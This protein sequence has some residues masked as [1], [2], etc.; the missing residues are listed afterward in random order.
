MRIT[1]LTK[2]DVEQLNERNVEKN[3]REEVTAL[4]GVYMMC[5]FGFLLLLIMLGSCAKKGARHE[6]PIGAQFTA[7]VVALPAPNKYEVHLAWLKLGGIPQG[8]FI[9]RVGTD[10]EDVL[11]EQLEAEK[12]S[13]SDSNVIAGKQYRYEFGFVA[14]TGN[15]KVAQKTV[16]I[17][18]DFEISGTV[19]NPRLTNFNRIFLVEG[20]RIITMGENLVINVSEVISQNGIIESFPENQTAVPQGDG[21]AGGTIEIHARSGQGTLFIYGSGENGGD[22]LPGIKGAIGKKGIQGKFAIST[23]QQVDVVCDCGRH[24]QKLERLIDEGSVTATLEYALEKTRHRCILQPGDG[25]I[26]EPGGTGANGGD[27][28]RGGDSAAVTVEITEPNTLE[29][30]AFATPGRGGHGGPGGVGG[31]GGPGGEPGNTGL[32]FYHVC[33]NAQGGPQGPAGRNGERGKDGAP[34][35]QLP[36]RLKMGARS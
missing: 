36:M 14:N 24:A 21:R 33:R 30:K 31:D 9:H 8:W 6:K 34:G 22:G 7:I 16:T 1:R 10:E 3:R 11:F 20:A 26:G 15:I 17:P 2:M 4:F 35:K 29:V 18:I 23:H 12:D 32:D 27:G 25:E 19:L 28:G 13:Y 5:I